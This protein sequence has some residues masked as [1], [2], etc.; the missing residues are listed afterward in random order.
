[1]DKI[2]PKQ[3]CMAGLLSEGFLVQHLGGQWGPCWLFVTVWGSLSFRV[4]R[5]R[6]QPSACVCS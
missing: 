5:R 1:M 3:D 6:G 2:P 4:R